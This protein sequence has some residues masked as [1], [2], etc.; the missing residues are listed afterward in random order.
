[1]TTTMMTN[2]KAADRMKL[3][4]LSRKNKKGQRQFVVQLL[5]VRD[6][7]SRM[8]EFYTVEDT[9]AYLRELKRHDKVTDDDIEYS[10]T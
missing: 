1:M 2:H 6:E 4:V 7:W 9:A 5:N 3:R 10:V 8:R